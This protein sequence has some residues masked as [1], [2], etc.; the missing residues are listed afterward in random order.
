MVS[1]ARRGRPC[2]SS[3]EV[4]SATSTVRVMA[5]LLPRPFAAGDPANHVIGE[6]LE[7]IGD[8]ELFHGVARFRIGGERLA[9]LFRPAEAATQREVLPQRIPL[10][11]LLP[12]QDATGRDA[13]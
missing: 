1:G 11:I 13:R 2:S 5:M 12:H 3:P 4:P 7:R 8:R 6:I 9:Q 10:V